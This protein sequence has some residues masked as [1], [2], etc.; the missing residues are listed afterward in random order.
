MTYPESVRYLYS[1]GNEIHT[2][3][4]GLERI[5]A[6][7]QALGNPHLSCRSLHVAGTN[8]KG[9]TSAM[10]EAGLRAAGFR[11]ALYTSPHLVE[12]TER[13]R[14]AGSPV[15]PDAFAAA[16]DEVHQTAQRMLLS[17]ALDLH[18][19]YFETV[20]AMAFVLFRRLGVEFAV[21][22]TG[23][24]GRLDATNVA[25][26]EICVLTPIDFDHQNFL[27]STIESIAAE[28][29]GILKPDCLAVVARQRPEALAVILAR[30]DELDVPI[31]F[32]TDWKI[33]S[34][35]FRPDGCTIRTAAGPVIECPLAGEHQA[36]NAL[37]A[38]IALDLLHVPPAGIAQTRWPAR[39]EWVHKRPDI[40]LDG[41]HNPAGALAL[42]AYIRRFF[43]GRPR[44]LV[45]AAMRDK[46]VAE[47]ASILFPLA[48]SILATQP[49]N[50]R[51]MPPETIQAL[52]PD[53]GRVT[54][55]PTVA[56]AVRHALESPPETAVFFAGSLFL[57]GE[58][59]PLL[60]A[61][62]LLRPAANPAG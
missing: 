41:A 59:R 53:P 38:A 31:V 40:I 39:L 18:P 34:L 2:A 5:T 12:P 20:T 50:S 11:T 43:S 44:R 4:L 42:A 62:N 22:E 33:D 48:G 29:A 16:F 28:K 15:A 58:A 52:A 60:L 10:I 7:L 51:A 30:A 27:G 37:A 25:R 17:G 32:T 23:L 54:V 19:T 47:I 56:E 1:L 6:L 21:L 3:K 49:A 14:I 57:A 13:I 61:E 55:I 36:E 9:S 8:G 45:F 24:G 26:A 35:D 46:A